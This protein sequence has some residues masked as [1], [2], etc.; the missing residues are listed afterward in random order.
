MQSTTILENGTRWVHLK[1]IA[2]LTERNE[3]IMLVSKG[4]QN[5]ISLRDTYSKFQ[6]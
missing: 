5:T 4:G 2:I 6:R 1:L 3:F